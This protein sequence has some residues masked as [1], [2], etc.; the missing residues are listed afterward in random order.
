MRDFRLYLKDIVEAMIAIQAFVEGMDFEAFA[1]DDKTSSAVIRK[2]EILGEATKNVP[3]EIRQ[4]Y[5]QVP[6]RQM[7]GM[8]DRLIHA[9][10]GVDYALVWQTI[11]NRI[12]PLKPIIE[13][14]RQDVEKEDADGINGMA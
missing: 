12:P 10:F 5:P 6:W 9:Y 3:D 1:A 13:Q 4:K 14:I 11:E 8:R 7:A 2:F